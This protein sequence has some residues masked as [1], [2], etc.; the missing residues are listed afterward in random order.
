MTPHAPLRFVAA[1][2]L[3]SCVS[4]ISSHAIAQVHKCTTNGK[5]TY[6]SGPCPNAT[7]APQPTAKELN[8]KRELKQRTEPK[9]TRS[10]EARSSSPS[11]IASDRSPA[12]KAAPTFRCDARKHCSQMTSC[13]EAKYFLANCPGVKMDGDRDGIPCEDQWC[14]SR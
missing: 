10:A 6:Q 12:P 14:S 8:A 7:R 4:L 13:A 5:V 1:T 2:L 11:P 3:A 9:E